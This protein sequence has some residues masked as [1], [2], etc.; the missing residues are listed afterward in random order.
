M[1]LSCQRG[2]FLFTAAAD[3]LQDLWRPPWPA[4]AC[5]CVPRVVGRKR[6]VIPEQRSIQ[7]ANSFKSPS[8][9]GKPL[10]PWG[11]LWI[12]S[13][14]FLQRLI[15]KLRRNQHALPSHP[16]RVDGPGQLVL[17]SHQSCPLLI[18]VDI[19]AFKANT[20][21]LSLLHSQPS[22]LSPTRLF[23]VPLT[24]FTHTFGIS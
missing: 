11:M 6:S 12:M 14:E 15:G 17:V 5:G 20:H 4:C 2:W 13:E 18:T 7:G 8:G 10:P 21:V 3:P 9:E 1:T 24:D 23:T 16:W 22:F 19:S